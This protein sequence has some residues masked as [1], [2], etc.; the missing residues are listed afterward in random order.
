MGKCVRKDVAICCL[1]TMS[2][3]EECGGFR[4]S[5]EKEREEGEEKADDNAVEHGL[6]ARV[7]I[8]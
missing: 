8:G 5:E 6:R 7:A 2:A 4:A 1:D 3:L